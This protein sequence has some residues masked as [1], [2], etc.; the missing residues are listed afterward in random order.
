MQLRDATGIWK[1][2]KNQSSNES[3]FR[4]AQITQPFPNTNLYFV[5]QCFVNVR[6]TMMRLLVQTK[7]LPNSVFIAAPCELMLK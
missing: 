3:P 4:Y 2:G 1:E 5:F 7:S 6:A